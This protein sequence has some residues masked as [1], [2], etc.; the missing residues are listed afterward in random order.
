MG[1]RGMDPK[2]QAIAELQKKIRNLESLREELG[3]EIVDQKIAELQNRL[4]PL[5]DTGGGAVTGNVD[6]GG[7]DFVGRDKITIINGSYVGEPPE[8]QDYTHHHG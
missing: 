3:D 6:T 5:V 7:G 8:S 2:Q 4:R 1:Y